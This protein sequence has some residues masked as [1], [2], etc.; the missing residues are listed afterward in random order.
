MNKFKEYDATDWI[1]V[2]LLPILT[3]T[4]I[5]IIMGAF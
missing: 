2:S 5:I 4:I 1:M 3:L